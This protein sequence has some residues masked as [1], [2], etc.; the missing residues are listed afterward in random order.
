MEINMVTMK[1]KP[2]NLVGR[3]ITVGMLAPNFHATSNQLDDV[4]LDNFQGKIKV[5]TSFIS[6]DT[7]VCDHQV[8]EFNKKAADISSEVVIV[9]ISKDLPF[10]QNKFCSLNDITNISVISDYKNS[11][12]G[13]NYGLLIKELGLLARATVIIDN[14]NIIRYIQIVDELTKEPNYQDVLD[15][16]R[17]IVNT[18]TQ[19][20]AEV[21]S[22]RCIPCETGTPTIEKGK[23]LELLQSLEGWQLVDDKKIVKE[24]KFK[25]FTEAK[26]FLDLLAT[27]AEEQGHHPTFTLMFY[28][29]KV[30]L[31]THI[32]GGL[33]TNDFIMARIFNNVS[34]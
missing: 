12:F 18:P 30:T 1:G 29:L 5:I 33:T 13:I 6:L 2:L 19:P 11:S 27:I 28:T 3:K 7:P 4:S 14:N 8:K 23:A 21:L 34:I 17:T 31:T 10:A 26:Y 9:G 24:F 22:N 25:N 15:N 16:L 20:S 32:S